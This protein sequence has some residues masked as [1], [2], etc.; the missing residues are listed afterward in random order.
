MINKNVKLAAI[1]VYKE[2][3]LEA[4]ITFLKKR[5]IEENDIADFLQEH[6]EQTGCPTK[7]LNGTTM[8]NEMSETSGVTVGDL[9][10]LG[11]T[12]ILDWKEVKYVK[13]DRKPNF[14]KRLFGFK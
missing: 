13:T 5:E 14:I 7:E 3:G 6:C 8:N 1:E 11:G 12:N 9:F 4:T 10:N 2:E